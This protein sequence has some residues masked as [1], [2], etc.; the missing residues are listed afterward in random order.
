MYKRQAPALAELL[1]TRLEE[2]TRLDLPFEKVGL[3]HLN[4]SLVFRDGDW[5]QVMRLLDETRLRRC[6]AFYAKAGA[7]IELNAS[8][9]A[10]GWTD[11]EEENLRVFRL[12]KEEGCRFYCGSDAHHPQA[13]PTVQE[14][15]PLVA[16]KLGL[17]AQDRYQIPER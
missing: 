12:A 13:L 1:L 17:C 8:C 10:P 3:A 11:F 15:L 4:C 9:F 6:F 7:G 14:W 16:E 2:L 5:H